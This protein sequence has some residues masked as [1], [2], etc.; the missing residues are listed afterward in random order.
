MGSQFFKDKYRI[1]SNKLRGY[2]YSAGGAYFITICTLGMKHTL[3]NV[4]N[5]EFAGNESSEITERRWSDLPNHYDNCIIDQFVIMPNHFHGIIIL[6]N[7][8]DIRG[9]IHPLSEM[10]RAFKSYSTKEINSL[11]NSA[12]RTFWQKNYYDRVIRNEKELERIREYIYFNPLRWY[13]DKS[14]FEKT[15]LNKI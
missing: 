12:G 1:N 5:G 9:K 2:D 8:G 11:Q 10:I 3:G 13:W 6:T 14:N 7:K 4:I 15:V